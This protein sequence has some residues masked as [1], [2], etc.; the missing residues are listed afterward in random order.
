MKNEIIEVKKLI[1][2]YADQVIY[3]LNQFSSNEFVKECDNLPQVFRDLEVYKS[4]IDAFVNYDLFKD[5][6]GNESDK[7][8]SVSNKS[9]RVKEFNSLFEKYHRVTENLISQVKVKVM[10]KT[11]LMNKNF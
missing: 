7:S 6:N 4:K 1:D 8:D 9:V 5:E 3:N 2:D 10:L 11:S